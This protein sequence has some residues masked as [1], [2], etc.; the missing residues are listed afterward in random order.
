MPL[1][2]WDDYPVHQ[3]SEFIRHVATSDRNFYDRYYFNCLPTSGEWFAIFGLGQ[4]PNLGT[5]DAFIDV[6]RGGRQHIVRAS[7]P[8]VDRADTSVGPLRVEVLEPLVRLRFVV[9]APEHDVEMD[10]TWEGFGPAIEEPR[11]YLRSQ[12]KVVFDTQR[13]AQMGSWSGTL[14]VAGEDLAIDPETCWGSRD[15]SWG[16][17][18]VGEPETDGIRQGVNVMEGLWSYFPMRFEDHSLFVICQERPDGSRPLTQSERVWLDGTV[19]D[20]GPVEHEHRFRPGTRVMV[21]STLRFPE[22][23]VEIACEPLLPN[24]VSLGTG[25]GMDADWRH[26]MYQGPEPVVQGLTYEVEEIEGLAQYGIVDH[27]ARF[28]YDD[29]V[30]YGLYEHGVF[31]PFPRY[32]MTDGGM[33]APGDG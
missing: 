8:L 32:G 4:Y 31:G 3:T 7:Q 12:G 25:Y 10:L 22:A 15:R 2:S 23:G 14:R 5:T 27:V 16:V 33:G 30:G 26:G 6:R 21:G 18:P 13:L 1:T 24:F 9:D 28:T 19:D 29:H 11:Q 20:L 17:R